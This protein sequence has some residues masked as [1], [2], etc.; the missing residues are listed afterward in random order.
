MNRF[1][2]VGML[3]SCLFAFQSLA[4]AQ[5]VAA[6]APPTAA[7]PTNIHELF[8]EDQDDRTGQGVVPKYA[9]DVKSRDAMRR[10]EASKLLAASELK[11]AEDF[12]D[13][14]FIFQHGSDPNDYLLAHI[15]AIE[16]ILKGDVSSKWLA[17]AT[18]DRYLQAIGQKQVFGTQYLSNGYSFLLTHKADP[19]AMNSPEANRQGWTQEPYDRTLVSDLLRGGF[20]VPDQATQAAR[21]RQMNAG[22]Q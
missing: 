3:F 15:L 18:L 5:A 19:K 2:R 6:Q 13:A 4:R 11:T 10:A 17:A 1:I 22:K 7:V 21:L 14:A 16:A 12:R 9:P 8:V 20:G